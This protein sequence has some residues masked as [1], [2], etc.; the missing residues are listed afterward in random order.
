MDTSKSRRRFPL[1]DDTRQAQQQAQQSLLTR[2]AQFARDRR[3]FLTGDH[4]NSLASRTSLDGA[5]T[6][7]LRS[8]VKNLVHDDSGYL[9]RDGGPVQ[10]PLIADRLVEPSADEKPVPLLEALPPLEAAFYACESNVISWEGKSRV[11]VAELS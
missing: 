5:C 6:Q 3:G 1:S 2:A 10:V 11:Q 8:L 4:H 7:D 9:K